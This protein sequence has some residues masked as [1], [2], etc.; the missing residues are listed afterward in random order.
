MAELTRGVRI[1]VDVGQVR[2]GI[3]R[4][5][6]DGILATPLVTLARDLTAA[7]DAVPS[8]LAELAALVAEH[9]AVGVVVGLPVNLA[10]KHGPAAVH[11]KAYADRLVDV[12]A[13][14]PVTLTD[15]RMSTVV[16]SRR[17]AERGVRGKRQR[18]VVDQAAAV[19]ILQSW[20]DAQRRR[21]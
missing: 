21:T 2:V 15:E 10:G 6:P 3:S 16:A 18:A 11:V 5:D 20:L 13:P 14:V 19:E 4:S 1:G 12:I 9:E 17:L 8:D 7:P